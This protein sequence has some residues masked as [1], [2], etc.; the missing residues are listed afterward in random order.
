MNLDWSADELAFQAE[1]RQFLTE[2]LPPDV[3]RAGRLMTS[4]Y[5]DHDKGMEWQHIL[6]EKGW[7]APGWRPEHGGCDWTTAQHYLFSRER[8]AAGAPPLSPWASTWW[9]M[10]SWNSARRRRRTSSCR[11]S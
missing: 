1:V 5:A 3:A 7:A 10:S 11:A 8:V 6:H 4:V 2:K 9:P